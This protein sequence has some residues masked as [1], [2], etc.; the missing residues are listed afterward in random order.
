MFYATQTQGE[1]RR[2]GSGGI[3]KTE[4]SVWLLAGSQAGGGEG[5]A[6]RARLHTGL[7]RRD[8]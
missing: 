3:S 1:K 6:S 4:G 2:H 8:G 7:L 5:Q